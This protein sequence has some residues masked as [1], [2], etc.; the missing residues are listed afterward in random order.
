MQT[1]SRIP[2]LRS[3]DDIKN[4]VGKANVKHSVLGISKNPSF[5]VWKVKCIFPAAPQ[6]YAALVEELPIDKAF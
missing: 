2:F 4:Q 6:E 1:S 5:D 3:V